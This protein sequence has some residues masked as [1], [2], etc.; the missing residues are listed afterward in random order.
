[1][2][3]VT[4]WHSPKRNGKP[5]SCELVST[6]LSFQKIGA[7]PV[8]VN[9]RFSTYSNDPAT[10]NQSLEVHLDE[11]EAT[12]VFSTIKDYLDRLA[13]SQIVSSGK[14]APLPTSCNKV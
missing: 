14:A 12:R 7:A 5:L 11:E 3:E 13:I 6:G 1:M 2:A 9:M 4:K 10:G 8:S